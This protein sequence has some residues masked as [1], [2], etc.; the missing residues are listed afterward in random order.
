MRELAAPIKADLDIL[1]KKLTG[2]LETGD[3]FQDKISA[4]IFRAGGK[5]VRPAL[6]LAI[7]KTLGLESENRFAVAAALEY[8]HTASL[9]HDDVIDAAGSRRGKPTVNA[10]WDNTIAILSGDRVHA[11]A[12]RLLICARSFEMFDSVCEAVQKMSESE[13]FHLTILWKQNTTKEE[14]ERVVHGKTA[15]LFEVSALAASQILHMPSEVQDGLASYGLNLGFAFQIIDDCLDFQSTEKDMGKP[16]LND[17]S[18]GKITLPLILAMKSDYEES[19]ELKN[20]VISVCEK[21]SATK[22]EL[23]RI[24]TLVHLANGVTLARNIAK[25]KVE[26]AKSALQKAFSAAKIQDAAA[27][28]ALARVPDLLLNRNN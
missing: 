13:I 18:E 8:I 7:A 26:S 3:A 9:L 19:I 22:D 20:L 1:E 27:L 6:F 16:V 14:Y 5:R 11:T 17:L 25:E 12:S 4:H 24:K 21:K 10:L 23:L 2:F 15:K 28:E